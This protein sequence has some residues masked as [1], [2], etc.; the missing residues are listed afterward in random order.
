MLGSLI[1]AGVDIVNF[2]TESTEKI[3][4]DFVD[5]ACNSLSDVSEKTKK[6]IYDYFDKNKEEIVS[7]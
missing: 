4:K 7:K 2:G 5:T 6:E 1:G 3:R